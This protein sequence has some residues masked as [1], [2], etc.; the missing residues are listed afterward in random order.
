MTAS[1]EGALSASFFRPLPCSASVAGKGP[2]H[3]DVALIFFS[4]P[5]ASS[6]SDTQKSGNKKDDAQRRQQQADTLKPLRKELD[7]IDLKIRSLTAEQGNLQTLL[8]SSKAASEI[9]QTGKRLKVIESDL[10]QLEERWLELTEQIET[11]TA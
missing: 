7:K 2:N 5:S 9:A 8:T 11:V 4:S 1:K 10:S 3:T 6:S